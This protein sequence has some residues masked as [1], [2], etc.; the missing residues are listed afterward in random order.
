MRGGLG[1]TLLTAFLM[2]IGLTA[3]L[4]QVLV[5]PGLAGLLLWRWHRRG[6]LG[7]LP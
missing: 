1:R 3:H 7:L 2:G 4:S 6:A 5:W